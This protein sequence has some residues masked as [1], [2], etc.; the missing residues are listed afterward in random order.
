MNV[1]EIT[2]PK[3]LAKHQVTEFKMTI[4]GAI[5]DYLSAAPDL[6]NRQ[7]ARLLKHDKILRRPTKSFHVLASQ[8]RRKLGLR[9]AWR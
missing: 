4:T 9:R 6:N 1:T 5:C 7:L 3:L 2:D 8:M